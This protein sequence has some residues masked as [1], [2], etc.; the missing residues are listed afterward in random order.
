MLHSW[1]HLNPCARP[2]HNNSLHAWRMI[3]NVGTQ[4]QSL[5]LMR[6]QRRFVFS[7]L[8]LIGIY[9]CHSKS[10]IPSPL[11]VQGIQFCAA[12]NLAPCA[13]KALIT[14]SGVP[15][16]AGRHILSNNLMIG[17]SL[18]FHVHSCTTGPRGTLRMIDRLLGGWRL[19]RLLGGCLLLELSKASPHV[20]V[21]FRA[22]CLLT[23][24][25]LLLPPP[26]S[27]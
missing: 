3:S 24:L 15:I 11:T 26:S 1:Y 27:I 17:F 19:Y 22:L 20:L 23:L 5:E 12:A 21:P 4:G 16:Q 6:E 9:E 18:G 10:S 13:L 2:S 14:S 8:L 7:N 25:S